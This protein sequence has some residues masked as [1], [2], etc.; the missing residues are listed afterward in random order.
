MSVASILEPLRRRLLAAA[1]SWDAALLRQFAAGRDPEA[2]RTLVKR[3]GPLV[4]GVARRVAGEAHADDVF[5]ATYI[6][7]ARHAA[8]VRRPDALP[9]WLHRTAFRLALNARRGENRRRAA[10]ARSPAATGRNPLDELTARELLAILDDEIERLPERDRAAL[11]LCCLDGMSLDEAA[12]RLGVSAGAVKGRLER[13]RERLRRNLARRGLIV[14]AVLAPGLLLTPPAVARTLTESTVALC[15]SG[16]PVP[17]TVAALLAETAWSRT[18]IALLITAAGFG[19]GLIAL[20]KLPAPQP[21]P[22]AAP[23]PPRV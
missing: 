18:R 11:V 13:G 20:A 23:A 16:N 14:P 7:L 9:V 21:P 1:A 4:L 10:E 17:D 8:A 6:K 12:G 5:Q 3:H 19:V 2:F 15:L 22:A